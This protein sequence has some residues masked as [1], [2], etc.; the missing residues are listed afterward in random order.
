M[1]E[2]AITINGIPL[3]SA[4]SMAVRVAVT[5]FHLECSDPEI[6]EGLGPIA[7]AYLDRLSE[8]LK[9]MLAP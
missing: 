6:R 3:T 4:Q 2:A 9:V 8:V 1:S 7:D 5:Q